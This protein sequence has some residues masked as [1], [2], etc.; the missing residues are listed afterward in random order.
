VIVKGWKDA[1]RKRKFV[2]PPH[3]WYMLRS[4]GQ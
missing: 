3:Y 4:R 2:L 1:V